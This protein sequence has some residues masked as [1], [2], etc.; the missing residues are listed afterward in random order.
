M[1][2]WWYIKPDYEVGV[3]LTEQQDWVLRSVDFRVGA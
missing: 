1:S 3:Q 2:E